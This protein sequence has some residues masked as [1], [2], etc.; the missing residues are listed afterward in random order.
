M[1]TEKVE[2]AV[3]TLLQATGDPNLDRDDLLEQTPKR[4]ARA[5]GEWFSGYQDDPARILAKSFDDV[6]GYSGI[7][8]LRD[9][10]FFSHCEHHLAQIE[11]S[12]TVA[13]LPGGGSPRAVGLSKLARLVGCFSRRLQIQERMTAQ[14]AKAMI[15]HLGCEGVGVVVTAV[16][17]CMT[18]RGVRLHGAEMVTSEMLGRFRGDRAARAEALALMGL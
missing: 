6:S 11:G 17:G 2:A 16:H 4:V 7:I 13:Y 10:P 1:D 12:A 15:D 14:I 8:V 18:T 3:T 5:W 9:I